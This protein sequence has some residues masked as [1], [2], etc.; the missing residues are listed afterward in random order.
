MMAQRLHWRLIAAATVCLLGVAALVAL[1]LSAGNHKPAPP[2][3]PTTATAGHPAAREITAVMV[4]TGFP[5]LGGGGGGGTSGGGSGG[6]GTVTTGGGGGGGT[7]GGGT[8]GG[9]TGS[10]QNTTVA[11]SPPPGWTVVN[12]DSFHLVLE[13]PGKNG[14]LGLESGGFKSQITLT[15]YAQSLV[16]GI[17]QGTTGAKICGKTGNIQLPNGPK[18][19]FIPLCYTLVPTN[20]QAVQLY[21]GLLVGLSGNIGMAVKWI[22]PA[23]DTI[24]QKFVSES[25]NVLNTVHWKLL[26]T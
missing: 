18:G 23:N 7:G 24:F 19:L 21:T 15:A 11:V 4:A 16:N 6:G 5:K 9:G 20:G 22:T 2:T 8:G 26:N 17:L 1:L 14:L 25:G 3:T 12:K 13:D 10:V